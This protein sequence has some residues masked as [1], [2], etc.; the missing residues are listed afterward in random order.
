MEALPESFSGLETENNQQDPSISMNT[1]PIPPSEHLTPLGKTI[2]ALL[3]SCWL[4]ALFCIALIFL[5][6][7]F[8]REILTRK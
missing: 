1:N 3:G 2:A 5:G 4:V 7:T 8:I 6:G